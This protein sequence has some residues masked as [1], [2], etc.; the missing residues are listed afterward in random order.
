MLTE[1]DVSLGWGVEEDPWKCFPPPPSK[2]IVPYDTYDLAAGKRTLFE[3][4]C[5]STQFSRWKDLH[6][7]LD[8]RFNIIQSPSIFNSARMLFYVRSLCCTDCIYHDK[9]AINRLSYSLQ[10]CFKIGTCHGTW[11]EKVKFKVKKG[12]R[13]I[14]SGIWQ[15]YD[16]PQINLKWTTECLVLLWS[17]K[18]IFGDANHEKWILERRC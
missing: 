13:F 2:D 16:L 5:R 6:H 14:Y 15:V 18:R 11:T 9:V 3:R 17:L 8:R 12:T 10:F 4:K 7:P 1:A